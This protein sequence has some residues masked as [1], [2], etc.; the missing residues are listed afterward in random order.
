MTSHS[1]DFHK[2]RVKDHYNE[3]QVEDP[4]VTVKNNRTVNKQMGGDHTSVKKTNNKAR[5]SVA[6][7]GFAGVDIHQE[8][9]KRDAAVI[10]PFT[11]DLR[12]LMLSNIIRA[13]SIPVKNDVTVRDNLM[14]SILL[15]VG[16]WYFG[17]LNKY[18]LIQTCYS[19]IDVLLETLPI[20][21]ELRNVA[22]GGGL[23]HY[24][25]LH[26]TN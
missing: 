11:R 17:Y 2:Q 20:S 19:F 22:I 10:T 18:V 13:H 15:G 9:Q 21:T 6:K 25:V 16:S 14:V 4:H 5:K 23:D 8:Y 12:N 24:Y 1:F 3:I 7:K 26:K